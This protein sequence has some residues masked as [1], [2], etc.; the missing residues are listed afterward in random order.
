LKARPICH[1]VTVAV[2]LETSRWPDELRAAGFDASTAAVFVAEGLS[3]YL[4]QEENGMLLDTLASL[5]TEGSRLGLDML[6]R[7][8]LDNP[9][10]APFLAL[11]EARASAGNSEQRTWRVPEGSSAG[12]ARQPQ[13]DQ[14]PPS[15]IAG[16]M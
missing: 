5:G 9:A 15:G 8:H 10:V 12:T 7:D 2:D 14:A 4:S 3:G 6:S 1:R 16:T 13:S 11:L